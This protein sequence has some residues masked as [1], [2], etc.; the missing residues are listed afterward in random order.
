MDDLEVLDLEDDLETLDLESSGRLSPDDSSSDAIIERIDR[1]VR[2]Y[3]KSV[4]TRA[5]HKLAEAAKYYY[6]MVVDDQLVFGRVSRYFFRMKCL[7]QSQVN[8]LKKLIAKHEQ[9]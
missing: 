5:E 4:A 1:R 2:S 6:D 7:E 3:H 9:D 8:M